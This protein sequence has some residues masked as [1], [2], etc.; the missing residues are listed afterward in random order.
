MVL[1]E[2]WGALVR[3]VRNAADERMRVDLMPS[4]QEYIIGRS[5]VCDIR[6]PPS[7]E[8]SKWVGRNHCQVYQRNGKVYIKDMSSIKKR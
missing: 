3:K 5:A 1:V 7:W 8:G 4:K 6:I 2:G